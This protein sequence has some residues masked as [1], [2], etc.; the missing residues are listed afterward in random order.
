MT[1]QMLRRGLQKAIHMPS[2]AAVVFWAHMEGEHAHGGGWEG[3][4]CSVL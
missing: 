2:H 1:I 3:V 4:M